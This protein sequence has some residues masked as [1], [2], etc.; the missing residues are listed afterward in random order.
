MKNT[1]RI[2]HPIFIG[3]ATIGMVRIEWALA[4]FGQIVPCNWGY[5]TGFVPIPN[6]APLNYL[7]ADAQNLIVT[8]F[9]EEQCEWLLLVEHDN[10]LPPDCFVRLNEYMRKRDV[11]IV[12]GLYFTKSIPSEPMVY[13]GRGNSFYTDW[14]IGDLVWVDGVPT[15]TLLI[16]RSIL[17][18][19][20]KESEE[21]MI[22]SN[23]TRR[24][25]AYPTS[26]W[27]DPEKGWEIAQGTTDLEWCARIMVNGIFKK[28]GWESYAEKDFPFLIDTNIFV[29]HIDNDG[30][31]FPPPEEKAKWIKDGEG[32]A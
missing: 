31:V 7:V 27:H 23:I 28:A 8:K 26:V 32:T 25:F 29:G 16:H 19:M 2:A 5:K 18:T 6:A 3:T 30:N 9:L 24:V 13:R 17:E 10:L 1:E 4:R 15:G 22:G 11:P 14:K 20:W 12:S 21:Y